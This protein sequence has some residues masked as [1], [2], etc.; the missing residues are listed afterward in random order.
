MPGKKNKPVW[1]VLVNGITLILVLGVLYLNKSEAR[2]VVYAFMIMCTAKVL[3]IDFYYRLYHSTNSTKVKSILLKLVQTPKENSKPK[4][5]FDPQTGKPLG[6]AS[7]LIFIG[8]LIF[9]T[10]I[11]MNVSS[12]RQLAVTSSRLLIEIKEAFLVFLIYEVKDLVWNGIIMNFNEDKKTNLAYNAKQLAIWAVA[13]LFL[14][15]FAGGIA[16]ITFS[17]ILYATLLGTKFLTDVFQD[18]K[19]ESATFKIVFSYIGILMLLAYINM[20]TGFLDRFTRL[21]S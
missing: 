13:I 1:S 7:Y 19:G 3:L 5:L 20:K 18:I 4:G 21:F 15:M 8:T 17:W 14:C 12:N 11:L 6:F 10:F 2:V 16:G 9:F